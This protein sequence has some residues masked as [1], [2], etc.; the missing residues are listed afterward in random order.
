MNRGMAGMVLF[1]A[2]EIMLFGGLFACYFFVRNQAVSWPPTSVEHV[3]DW[4]LPAILTAVLISSSITAHFGILGLKAGNQT[5]FKI[6]ILCAIILGAFFIGGQI[7]EWFSLMDEGLNAKSGV[8]GSTFY[9]ITGFHGAH[10]IAGLC[11]LIVVF[12]RAIQS[13]FTPRRHVFADAAVLYWHF[14][15]VVWVFVFSI[16]YVFS[17]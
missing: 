6:G 8:Y 9:V 5:L 12:A 3:A 10:V 4:Q 1:I 13:D 2:S 14:V 16:I 11:M 17:Q 15:D 7:Y